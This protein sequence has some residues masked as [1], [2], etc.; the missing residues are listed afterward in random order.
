M[1]TSYADT[2]TERCICSLGCNSN[3]VSAEYI[4]TAHLL[5]ADAHSARAPSTAYCVLDPLQGLSWC[6]PWKPYIAWNLHICG[7]TPPHIHP[8]GMSNLPHPW[9]GLFHLWPQPDE[10]S[11]HLR[12]ESCKIYYSSTGPV[13]WNT[14]TWPS[15]EAVDLFFSPLSPLLLILGS[16]FV[17]RIQSFP[18][19]VTRISI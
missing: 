7:T 12:S 2:G 9:P 13:R 17:L 5:T 8:G 3:T 16:A 18:L 4:C 15:V 11:S 1:F 10:M 14:F 6:L 19:S